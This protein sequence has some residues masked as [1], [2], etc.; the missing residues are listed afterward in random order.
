[1][2]IKKLSKYVYTHTHTHTHTCN[3]LCQSWVLKPLNSFSLALVNE[4]FKLCM[5]LVGVRRASITL[6]KRLLSSLLES[7]V[8]LEGFCS[9]KANIFA[10]CLLPLDL[11]CYCGYLFDHTYV[12]TQQLQHS[13]NNALGPRGDWWG[14]LPY[15]AQHKRHLLPSFLVGRI[16]FQRPMHTVILLGTSLQSWPHIGWSIGRNFVCPS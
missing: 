7:T 6:F 12:A 16:I 4:P 8:C 2:Y 1:M 10:L 13:W 9:L 15:M 5:V 14:G 11:P 3:I